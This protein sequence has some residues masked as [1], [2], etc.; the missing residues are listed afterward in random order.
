MASSIG[1]LEYSSFT[2]VTSKPAAASEDRISAGPWKYC[3]WRS[4]NGIAPPAG[5]SSIRVSHVRA[6]EST[7]LLITKRCPSDSPATTGLAAVNAIIASV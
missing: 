4:L 2:D 1:R 7:A 5:V 3:R 6:T